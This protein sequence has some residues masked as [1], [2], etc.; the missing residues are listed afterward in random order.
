[1]AHVVLIVLLLAQHIMRGGKFK[2][3]E[4]KKATMGATLRVQVAQHIAKS[5]PDYKPL[6]VC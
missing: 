3:L 5:Q 6:L 1:M 4:P 2:D